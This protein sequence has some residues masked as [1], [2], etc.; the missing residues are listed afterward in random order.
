MNRRALLLLDRIA[1]RHPL[2]EL[3]RRLVFVR[4]TLPR[5]ASQSQARE[6]GQRHVVALSNESINKTLVLLAN[7]LDTAVES[8]LLRAPPREEPDGG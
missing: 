4:Q 6:P 2:D 8:G 3:A 5:F 7:I 1:R